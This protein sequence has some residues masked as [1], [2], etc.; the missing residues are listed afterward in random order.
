MSLYGMA[1]REAVRGIP[2]GMTSPSLTFTRWHMC[3]RLLQHCLLLVTSAFPP[4]SPAAEPKSLPSRKI[5]I[6]L[7]TC[8]RGE[9]KPNCSSVIM[10]IPW[11]CQKSSQQSCESLRFTGVA[12][13][14]TSPCWHPDMANTVVWPS[15]L[16]FLLCGSAAFQSQPFTY[17]KTCFSSLF[18]PPDCESVCRISRLCTTRQFLWF[19]ATTDLYVLELS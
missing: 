10:I 9:K 8:Y 12:L 4:L 15:L 2:E 7:M 18:S 11:F 16:L 13:L 6:F 3:T 17:S 14:L 5:H 19:A 1:A